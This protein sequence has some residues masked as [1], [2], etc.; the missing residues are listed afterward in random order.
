ML[1]TK[2]KWIWFSLLIF[3]NFDKVLLACD[4]DTRSKGRM[5]IID[6]CLGMGGRARTHTSIR[7]NSNTSNPLSILSS[8]HVHILIKYEL[9]YVSTKKL[10][11]QARWKTTCNA[12]HIVRLVI[13]FSIRY[14]SLIVFVVVVLS[15]H[16]SF[17]LS[18]VFFS[19]AH[20]RWNRINRKIG[21]HIY[22]INMNW[23]RLPT[24]PTIP[25]VLAQT[26]ICA[27]YCNDMSLHAHFLSLSH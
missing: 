27:M 25:T 15:L 6:T 17:S 20:L 5:L 21:L 13:L 23:Y 26:W 1:S 24:I 3:S 18:F 11:E 16:C 7:I 8:H 10:I 22:I 2:I 14:F 12:L 9:N 19:L 4:F